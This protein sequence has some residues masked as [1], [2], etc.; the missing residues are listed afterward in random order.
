MTPE[1]RFANE[2]KLWCG[3][4]GYII[5]R[6][7]SGMFYDPHGNLIPIGFKG[8][9]DYL[10]IG[11]DG[12]IAFAELKVKPNRPTTE[13]LKFIDEMHKRNI[14]AAVIYSLDELSELLCS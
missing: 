3:Q 5:I 7:Q 11:R 14:K 2:V 13:Q 4:H 9:S 6:Q 12:I 10:I 8:L 1:T